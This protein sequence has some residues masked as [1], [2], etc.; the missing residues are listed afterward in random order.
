L[1]R[2]APRLLGRIGFLQKV[3]QPFVREFYGHV[4]N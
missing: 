1:I 2:E 3:D 4:K